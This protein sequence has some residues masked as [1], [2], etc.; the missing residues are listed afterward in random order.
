MPT[1]FDYIDRDRIRVTPDGRLTNRA[2]ATLIGVNPKTLANWR[3]LGTGPRW[4]KVG[5]LVFYE[6]SEIQKFIA[7]AAGGTINL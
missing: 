1:E 4:R 5:K 7:S 2:A 3:S 6:L